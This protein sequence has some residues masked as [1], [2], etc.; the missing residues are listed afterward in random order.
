MSTDFNPYSASPHNVPG[1]PPIPKPK[2]WLIEPILSTLFCCLPLGIA[3]I[4]FAAQVDSKYAS[5]DYAGASKAANTAKTLTLVSVVL[6][7][8]G[9]VVYI[10]LMI[11][12]AA[13][14]TQF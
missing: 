5:G 6:G 2:N 8:S 1:Q 4:V 10:G 12:G 11:L 3:A 9:T 7:L 13:A 14:N